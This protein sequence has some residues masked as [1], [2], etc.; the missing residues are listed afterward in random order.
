MELNLRLRVAKG[1]AFYEDD[2]VRRMVSQSGQKSF[3]FSVSRKDSV[4]IV[5]EPE[6]EL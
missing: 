4:L 5:L 2:I 6:V 1:A 3:D